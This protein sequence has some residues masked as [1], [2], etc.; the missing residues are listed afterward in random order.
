MQLVADEDE[1]V[2]FGRHPPQRPE[3][4]VD[5]LGR[6][7]G[8]RLVE[9]QDGRAAVERLED[10]DT[11]LLADRQLPYEGAGVHPQAVSL[12][13][14]LDPVG[15]SVRVQRHAAAGREAEG[16]ILRH[17]QGRDEHKVL[18]D[19]ADTV[20]DR[21]GRGADG[22]GSAVDEDVP[23]VRLI[24][25]V[26]DAH[27]RR[28]AGA[29]LAQ[30]R[31]DLPG[32]G[33]EGHPVVGD[34]PGEALDDAAQLDAGEVVGHGDAQCHRGRA[35]DGPAPNS[36]EPYSAGSV[37]VMLPSAIPAAVWSARALTSAGS[38]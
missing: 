24:Q 8:R 36:R 2:A 11:L 31:V 7:H 20:A 5:F 30:Q 10:F 22:H 16:D 17:R 21:V 28:L 33:V 23:G 19:H 38:A 37:M 25:P 29:V 18:M 13:Q 3:Q 6:Q 14:L 12:C 32:T 9:N 27:Q 4:L 34:D 26:Q 15:H 1:G 35:V